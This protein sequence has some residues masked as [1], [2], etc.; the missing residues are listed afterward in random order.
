MERLK[1]LGNAVKEK[2][3]KKLT[4]L[5][6]LTALFAVAV[7]FYAILLLNIYN[8][9][10]LMDQYI[11]EVPHIVDERQN[12]LETRSSVFKEDV[13]ARGKMGARIYKWESGLTEEERLEKISDTVS[14]VSV[15][16]T[17][18]SGAVLSTTG[19]ITPMEE[20]EKGVRELKPLTPVFDLYS[21]Y[22]ESEN[23]DGLAVVMVPTEGD[24][25]HRLIFEFT[26]KPMQEIYYTL[27][28]WSDILQR[29]LSG[30]DAYAFVRVDGCDP[31]GYPLDEFT[32][33]EQEELIRKISAVFEKSDSFFHM[34]DETFYKLILLQDR[35]ALALRMPYPERNADILFVM[36]MAAF[37]NTVVYSAVTLSVF[38][39]CNLIMFL[40]YSVRLNGANKEK[41]DRENSRWQSRETTRPGR[42]MMLVAV[43]GFSI[44]LLMLESRAMIAYIGMT[45]RLILY[46]NIEYNEKQGGMIRSSY[47]DIYK[48]RT[49]AAAKLLMDH[50][51]LRTRGDLQ[52]LNDMVRADYLMLFD[53]N[54]KLLVASNSYTGF[55]VSG[56]NANMSEE[57][58]AVLFGYPSV[59]VGPEEDPFNNRQQ[60]GT[61]IL[62]TKENG[63]ADGFLLAVFDAGSMN[64]ELANTSLE[65][66]VNRMN[67]TNE[68][69]VAVIDDESGVFIAHSDKDTI[70]LEAQYFLSEEAYGN[71][72]EGF[73]EYDGQNMYVS[74]D[75]DGSKSFLCMVRNRQENNMDLVAVLIIMVMLVIIAL[76]YCPRA[77]TLFSEAMDGSKN[78][79][80]DAAHIENGK[81][82]P[83]MIFIN[84]YVAF[85]TLMAVIAFI[86]AYEGEWIAF[87]FVFGGMW[88][89]GIHL[90]SL[91]AALFV[92]SVTLCITKLL[93]AAFR[94]AEIRA[95]FRSRTVLRLV[96]SLVSYSVAVFLLVV[97]LYMFGV[98][99]MALLASAGI[100]S[101]AVGM[102]AKDLVADVLAG[103]FLA[104][105]DSIHIGDEVSVGTWQGLVTDM[106]IRTTKITDE[107]RNV[108]VMNNSRVNDVVN[109]SWQKTSCVLEMILKCTGDREEI[110]ETLEMAVEAA[111]EKMPELYGSLKLE[112]ITDITKENCKVRLSYI[113]AEVV[114]ES[115]T[116]RLQ[117]FIEHLVKQEED[118]IEAPKADKQGEGE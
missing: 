98:N 30:M 105:E 73:T 106:G 32:K 72:Y 45:R 92:L 56:P 37:S 41:K 87:L 42:L 64:S 59:T 50:K 49:E 36:P 85:Y 60:I 118:D 88:S 4:A 46:N 21:S 62:L 47:S 90:F 58:R 68:F 38:M 31:V 65:S 67:V 66:T 70:G 89:R 94:R 104:V 101:I 35:P 5:T 81:K 93:R 80:N 83:L 57:Y 10:G 108:K 39:V 14:A 52:E 17:D 51:E 100:V 13:I 109:M 117:E 15:T 96:N 23:K 86:V 111:S 19:T 7:V 74:T 33:E 114:R 6:L 29:A 103:V 95:D 110:E 54:G 75:S 28:D 99:T 18:E 82:N 48:T 84:G 11:R 69:K 20:F 71:D 112:G 25:G 97:I 34:G 116:S 26:C 102:G 77:Y 24:S 3:G 44:M 115:V 8:K 16:L 76:L 2:S 22:E 78:R 1:H 113:C 63:E 91:W 27:Y 107:N 12:E 55:S 40:F 61:A 79:L 9:L 43:A 53:V